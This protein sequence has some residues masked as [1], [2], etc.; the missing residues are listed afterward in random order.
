MRR[1]SVALP[2][3]LLVLAG[4]SDDPGADEPDEEAAQELVAAL[5]EGLSEAAATDVDAADTAVASVA[6]AGRSGRSA[7]P[8]YEEIVAGMDGI[9]PTIEV[10]EVEES[11]GTTTVGLTWEWPVVEP[12]DLWSYETAVEVVGR[13]GDW[14]VVWA[15][16]IVEPSL[17]ADEVLQVT[18]I[19]AGRGDIYGADGEVLV[20]E[21]PVLRFG[22]DRV[23]VGR[24]EAGDSA[25][26]LAQL[27]GV[28]VAPYVEAVRAAGDRAFVEAISF[29]EAEVPPAVLAGYEQI[30]GAVALSDDIALAPTRDFAAPIL[31]RVGPVTAEMV[32]A[33]PD[34]YRAG[35]VAGV[36][37]L[38]ARYDE[39]L[40]GT[41]GRLVEA[42]SETEAEPARDLFRVA[43]ADG[44]PLDLTL[45]RSLQTSAEELLADVASGSALVAIRPSDGAILAAANGPGNGGLNLATYGQFPP[46][47]T[48]KIV[49][50]LALLRAGLTPDSTVSCPST[51]TVDGKDFGNY[52]DY[53][54]TAT[55]DI[56]LRTAVAQSCNTAF[57]GA[58]DELADGDLADAAASLGLG[59]DH[60]LGF[61][62]FF[63]SVEPPATETEAA[64]D[65][66][67]QGTILASPM[68]MAAVVASV[69]EGRLVVPRLVEQVEVSDHDHTPLT[70]AE[71]TQL[72]EMLR[73]VVTGGS[74]SQLADVPGAPVI[75]K[76]GTAE[77]QGDGGVQTH[78]WMVAAQGDLAVAVFVEIGESGSRTAG[79]ILEAF[80]RAAG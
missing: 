24:A 40:G 64:A 29:R 20:T 25:R 71:A 15:P 38:Q 76:T 69:Q 54:S 11:D 22:I 55:G 52:S 43:E 12:S 21:R 67:G 65:L 4:C 62:A 80:L 45:D 17:G 13:D 8:R 19:P 46:G 34:R 48:F 66:I 36:S 77:F 10:G 7:A 59:V 31:G 58:R 28:D 32:E 18:T 9:M 51:V 27:V 23:R 14:E 44:E 5:A 6:Y 16:T 41:P 72:R 57:I 61:P 75:A 73:G 79:P 3:C 1:I 49:S 47:S 42:V 2:I 35:D 37:G 60:D 33:D 78:A 26:A 50:S 70:G 74:G 30:P 68:A 63:G 53:P 39:Q 56:P